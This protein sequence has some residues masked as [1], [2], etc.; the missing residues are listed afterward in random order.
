VSGMAGVPRDCSQP[1]PLQIGLFLPSVAGF[2]DGATARWSDLL[3]MAE[4]AAAVGFDALWLADHF[5]FRGGE[6]RADI[7]KGLGLPVQPTTEQDAPLGAW[8]AWS[9]LAALA[10][11][12]PRV[13]LG[14]IVTCTSYRHP[15][16]LAKMADTVEEI[17]GGRLI[18]GLGAGDS[19]FEHR[20]YG[21]AFDHRVS[22]FEEAL[23]IIRTLLREGQ[24]DFAGTYYQV[25]DCELR[26]RGPRRQ[27]PPILIGTLATGRRMLRLA[28]EQADLWNGWLAAGRS[29]PDVLPPVL[30][31]VDRACAEHGRDPATLLR[32][33]AVRVTVLEQAESSI[34]PTRGSADPGAVAIRGSAEEI[35][36]VL[37]AFVRMGISSMQV[38]L[39][40]NTRAGIEAFAPVLA[41]L[42]RSR[43]ASPRG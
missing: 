32:S 30:A 1:R 29:L 9:L 8:E 23:T 38:V 5:W 22:R 39:V 31:A 17:S 40:P 33:V 35:A 10:A 13:N 27:G 36:D 6:I 14:T 24:C 19:A 37:G 18:L 7:L 16:L 2:M 4:H 11:A 12:V 28:V 26:P 3:A 43:T 21:Y 20:A 25:R 42:D 34:D 41:L 15:A